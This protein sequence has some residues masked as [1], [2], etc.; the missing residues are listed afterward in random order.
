MSL[1]IR[2][3]IW[4]LAIIILLLLAPNAHCQ[5]S[6]TPEKKDESISKKEDKKKKKPKD[7]PDAIGDPNRGV[8][9]GVNFYSLE[10]EMALG[11]QIAQEIEKQAKLVE[12]PIISEYVNRLG[13]NLVRNSD[14][15]V[16]FT[17][18][19][20]NSDEINALSLPGGFFFVN[21][22]LILY[23]ENEA[24]LASAMAHEIAHVTARHGTRQA[25]RG[26]IANLATIPL[27]SM[28]GW[29]GYGARQ[30][31]GLAVPLGFL[32]FS[33]AFEREAD[34]LGLQYL[35]KTGYD[36]NEFVNLFE[37]MTALQKKRPSAISKFFSS[38]P[39]TED[40]TK[41][42]QKDIQ[43][44]LPPRGE[45]VINTSEFMA[46]QAKL[47]QMIGRKKSEDQSGKP[48]LRK[49]PSSGKIEPVDKDEKEKQKEENDRPVLKRR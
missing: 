11:K 15:K 28:G 19:V 41:E 4:F 2:A 8:G 48:T 49:T 27:I 31:V 46:V 45:Y 14:A 3:C 7:D 34:Y 20:I 47:N 44:V 33:R 42:S 32:Q 1:S 13:Q 40:R 23:A 35:Y 9:K 36:P 39:M 26:Q 38:H 24:Q 30:A 10:K 22:G 25:T 6:Q 43:Q 18:K 16:P 37:K 17:I 29:G 5:E 21:A 12:D